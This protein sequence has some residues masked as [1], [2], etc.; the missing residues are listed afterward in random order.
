MTEIPRWRKQALKVSHMT[1][2]VN[3]VFFIVALSLVRS[4]RLSDQVWGDFIVSGFLLG[5]VSIACGVLG[6]G[7]YRW[8][9]ILAGGGESFVWWLMAVGL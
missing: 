6:K 2:C 5:V 3:P 8:M 1:V 4:F 7:P 9:S